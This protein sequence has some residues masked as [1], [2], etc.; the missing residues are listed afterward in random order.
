MNTIK[1]KNMGNVCILKY[2]R[3]DNNIDFDNI[4]TIS[5]NE[6]KN[7]IN[8]FDY[9]S[10][11]LKFENK[12]NI[13][14]VKAINLLSP[15][16]YDIFIKYLYLKNIDNDYIKKMYLK[17]IKIFNNYKEPDGSKKNKTDFL[18][19][20][21]KLV[22]YFENGFD[23]SKSIVPISNQNIIIDGSHRI[24][25]SIIKNQKVSCIKFDTEDLLFDFRFFKKRG[26]SQEYL[27][28]VGFAIIEL[29]DNISCLVFEY[30]NN[31]IIDIMYANFDVYYY[32]KVSNKIIFL[33]SN[34]SM[35][36]YLNKKIIIGTENVYNE[37]IN[38]I[39]KKIVLRYNNLN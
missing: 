9:L 16:N 6:L 8:N 36:F 34:N 27:D 22:L 20:T 23:S 12:M 28:L 35:E 19:S 15:L 30:N 38:F 25:L 3:K 5:I 1:I 10:S 37:Y 11:F 4:G 14:S 18:N 17:H 24:A 33:F 26:F 13:Y 2:H 21:K 29:V 31:S 39:N 7:I 32:K